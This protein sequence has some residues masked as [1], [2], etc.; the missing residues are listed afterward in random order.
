M[1]CQGGGYTH[2]PSELEKEL[3]K[4]LCG[5]LTYIEKTNFDDFLKNTDFKEMGVSKDCL[6][7]WWANHK[8][9]DEIRR[10]EEAE[11]KEHEAKEKAA[12]EEALKKKKAILK[13]LT[14]EEKK[15]LGLKG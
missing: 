14:K 10:K 4:M 2:E 8:K 11:E 15:I 6:M 3:S 1:P 13:K 9:E 7:G 5:A 12:K